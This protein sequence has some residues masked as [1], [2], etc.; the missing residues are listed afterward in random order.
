MDEMVRIGKINY[1]NVW[2]VFYDF[3]GDRLQARTALIEQTPTEL[4]RA[5]LAGEIEMGFISAFA[6]LQNPQRYLLFPDLSISAQGEVSSILLFHDRP[7]AEICSGRIALPITSATSV[8]MLKVILEGMFAGKPN[9]MT[10]EPDLDRM[11]RHCQADAALLIGDDA[12][13]ASFK[14]LTRYVTDLGKLWHERTG[15]AMTYAVWAIR[16]DFA[17]RE[18][19]L[20]D[21]IYGELL[22]SLHEGS[23]HLNELAEQA[24]VSYGGS[25]PYWDNYY[26]QLEYGFGSREHIAMRYY[27]TALTGIGCSLPPFQL[28][29]WQPNT[30]NQV[31]T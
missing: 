29:L 13:R 28:N 30:M 1:A 4:N 22:R 21:H 15:H 9:Y 31:K 27:H 14:P 12:I 5:L 18:P 11:I 8:H 24:A 26:R 16:E 2:P 23:R 3:P 10:V 25:R 7:I 19:E 20:I 6:Y 17:Q